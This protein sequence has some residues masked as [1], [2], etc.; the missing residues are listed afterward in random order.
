MEFD[1]EQ[2]SLVLNERAARSL[3]C[4]VLYTLE[5]W[6]GEG[7][8]DQEALFELKTTLSALVLEY[9]F[10]RTSSD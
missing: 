4:A 7:F 10:S 1:E 3:L 5:K 9:E 6:S 2:F 8:I